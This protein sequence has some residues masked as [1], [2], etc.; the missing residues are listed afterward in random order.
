MDAMMR[1]TTRSSALD[2][3]AVATFRA[4]LRGRLIRPDESGYDEARKVWNGMID[5]R[6]ALIVRCAGVADVIAGVDF[7][8]LQGL[9]IAIRGGNFGVVTS[10]EFK[11]HPVSTVMVGR[12]SGRWPR[13]GRRCASTATS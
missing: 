5:R 6:P 2:E 7:A 9:P 12:S 1:D 10:F 8:R 13:R 11:L 3:G 4:R